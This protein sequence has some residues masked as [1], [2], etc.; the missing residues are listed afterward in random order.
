MVGM[1]EPRRGSAPALLTKA[2]T[3][4]APP[5]ATASATVIARDAVLAAVVVALLTAALA[6]RDL[7][8]GLTPH[9]GWVVVILMAARHGGRGFGVGL[10]AGLGALALTALG[11]GR[12]LVPL[13]RAVSNSIPDLVA[14]V[15]SMLVAVV[16][17]TREHRINHLVTRGEE[18]VRKSE[19]DD[20]TIGALRDAAVALRARADRFDHCLTFLRDVAARIESG[21]PTT[22]S[23]GELDLALART[24]AR[25]GAV[26]FLDGGRPRTLASV[27]PWDD[28]Q[29]AGA[30]DVFPDRTIRAAFETAAPA[31]AT[32]LPDA[33]P[34][35]CELAT[36]IVDDTG[37]VSGVLALRGVPADSLRR[38]LVHDVG[39]IA[40]WCA[41]S[42]PKRTS[43][44]AE[45]G[46][47]TESRDRAIAN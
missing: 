29:S 36:P 33:G 39:L 15:V 6:R 28:A 1:R 26:V 24:G 40:R 22:A 35:D 10:V 4:A 27:G 5:V 13:L 30:P 34:S 46:P 8:A 42:M 11:T 3:A 32:D 12:E 23:Q 9:L 31:R 16:T 2:A 19:A 21:D 25:A 37:R 43:N 18:L 44:V 41:K 45:P 17:S 20:A 38:P 14:L 7:G 47:S